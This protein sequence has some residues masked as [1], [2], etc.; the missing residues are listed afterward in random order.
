M[1]K[2]ARVVDTRPQGLLMHRHLTE[3]THEWEMPGKSIRAVSRRAPGAS[4]R[5]A[6]ANEERLNAAERAYLARP[7]NRRRDA[8]NAKRK[9]QRELEAA[10]ALAET[11]KTCR[12]TITA[13]GDLSRHS[14]CIGCPYR[15]DCRH[16]LHRNSTSLRRMLPTPATPAPSR[17]LA[18]NEAQARAT[19]EAIAYTSATGCKH[20]SWPPKRQ[21]DAQPWRTRIDRA[22]NLRS[23]TTQYTPS[24]VA[25]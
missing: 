19:A 17:H 7:S 25:C 22:T 14:P 18:E 3:S 11:S 10:Q 1:A 24:G 23:L 6:A 16:L 9:R 13:A 21:P 8:K 12:K 20:S 2:A 5:V 4:S 15:T